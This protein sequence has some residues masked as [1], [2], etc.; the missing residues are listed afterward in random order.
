MIY[1]LCTPGQVLP[2]HQKTLRSC[3]YEIEQLF[4]NYKP[5][6]PSVV[7]VRLTSRN[8][9]DLAGIDVP[10]GDIAQVLASN[11]WSA[12]RS[13]LLNEFDIYYHNC[14]TARSLVAINPLVTSHMTR[15]G[16]SP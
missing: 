10:R 11:D 4:D 9:T 12:D 7:L 3:H 6:W 16:G 2:N 15:T 1:Q 13:K 14:V 5:N 8:R